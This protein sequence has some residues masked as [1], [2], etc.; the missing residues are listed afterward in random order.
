MWGCFNKGEEMNELFLEY[1]PYIKMVERYSMEFVNFTKSNPVVGGVFGAWL[2]GVVTYTL[3]SIPLKILEFLK[4]YATISIT[5]TNHDQSFHHF[6][7]WVEKNKDVKSFR[8]TR[9]SNGTHGYD[10]TIVSLGLGYH[11]MMFDKVPLRVARYVDSHEG[12][13]TKESITISTIGFSQKTLLN[14]IKKTVPERV[15]SLSVF[16]FEDNNWCRYTELPKR[17]WCSV[18]LKDGQKERILKF[19]NDFKNSKDWYEE[20]GISHQTGIILEGPPGTGKTSFVKALANELKMNLAFLKAG[21]LTDVNFQ[22]ALNTLPKNTIVL[23]ED[24]DSINSL[25]DR[26]NK[27]EKSPFDI[28]EM[29]GI[30]LSGFL[31]AVDGI[32]SSD[33][34][35]LIATTNTMEDLDEAVL[36]PGRFDTVEHFGHADEK[37]VANLYKKFYKSNLDV[38]KVPEKLSAAKVENLFVMNKKEPDN[39]KK[40]L[41]EVGVS[42]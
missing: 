17:L 40:S 12:N 19:I 5:L 35:I 25:K 9:V 14:L 15:E 23:I 32:F 21:M 18:I 2:L 13:K 31:N 6:L 34:R 11:Y 39:A 20:M 8:T 29:T 36:R 33:G 10:H 42:L 4:R 26:K 24:F 27:K 28:S 38:R 1:L 7:K 37:M 22:V 16:L 30:S 41:Q 3:K